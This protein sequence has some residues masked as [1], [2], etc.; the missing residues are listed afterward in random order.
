MADP[1]SECYRRRL[2][3]EPPRAIDVYLAGMRE[4]ERRAVESRLRQDRQRTAHCPQPT[5][6]SDALD[7]FVRGIVREVVG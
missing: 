3:P 1:R 4:S 5:T 7:A 6:E 2:F